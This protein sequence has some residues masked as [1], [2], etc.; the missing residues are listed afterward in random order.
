MPTKECV[1]LNDVKGLFLEPGT[2]GEQNKAETVTMGKYRS[3]DLS[4][5][6]DELLAQQRIFYNQ[7]GTAASW[8]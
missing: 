7:I 5:E 6:D 3:L 2:T 1:W 8:I 4:V